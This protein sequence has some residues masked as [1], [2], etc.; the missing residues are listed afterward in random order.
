MRVAKILH[1]ACHLVH[2]VHVTKEVER[3]RKSTLVDTDTLASHTSTRVKGVWPPLNIP[4]VDGATGL[5]G[6]LD[7]SN[8]DLAILRLPTLR[9][10]FDLP[11]FSF[12]GRVLDLDVYVCHG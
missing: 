8:G 12:G 9:G 7:L 11:G 2:D 1:L 3:D 4:I 6:L 5:V 10:L